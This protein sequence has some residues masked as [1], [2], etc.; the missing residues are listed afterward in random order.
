MAAVS[1]G[2]ITVTNAAAVGVF[3]AGEALAVGDCCY[4]LAT[5]Y[6]KASNDVDD[7]SVDAKLIALTAASGDNSYFIGL[8]TGSKI[9]STGT[10]FTQGVTY[11]VGATPGKIVPFADLATTNRTV[12]VGTAST[13]G[14]LNLNIVN[15]VIAQP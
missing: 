7:A 5:K 3:V 12:I 1:W 4:L 2:T 6:K 14:I 9:G 11:Y 8:R 10:P 15:P 13:S